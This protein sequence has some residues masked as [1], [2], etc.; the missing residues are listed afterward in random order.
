MSA[1]NEHEAQIDAR[2]VPYGFAG[3][4]AYRH[5]AVSDLLAGGV[6]ECRFGIG[7]WSI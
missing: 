6:V 4:G 3:R 1:S 5:S 7:D 2:G